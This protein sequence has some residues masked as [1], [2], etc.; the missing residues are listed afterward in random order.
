MTE[1]EAMLAAQWDGT[2][3]GAATPAADFTSYDWGSFL[4]NGL[5]RMVDSV[6]GAMKSSN[7][8]PVTYGS[9]P[10][11]ISNGQQAGGI[12]V[13]WLIIGAVALFLVA[14]RG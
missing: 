13:T 3:W 12:P 11:A 6:A 14:N 4:N 5:P 10:I 1:Q 8:K 7:V 9:R 2:G